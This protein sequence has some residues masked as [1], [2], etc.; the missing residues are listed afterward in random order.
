[1]PTLNQLSAQ[2]IDA[3]GRP[4]DSLLLER[5]KDILVQGRIQFLHRAFDKYGVD[6]EYVHP[7]IVPLEKVDRSL[8][9]IVPVGLT[10][11]KSVKRIPK[12]IRLSNETVPFNYVGSVDHSI[13]FQYANGYMMPFHKYL[14]L[15]G[16]GIKYDFVNEYLYI[17]N[18]TKLTECL[19]EALFE[20]F[21]IDLLDNTSNYERDTMEFP[22]YGDMLND[23]VNSTIQ[24]LTIGNDKAL[25]EKT[26]TRDV[27]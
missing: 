14:K 27:N 15:L 18:N 23:L 12:V 25:L 26:T 16:G 7:Y 4:F 13:T 3:L 5:V 1:M 17:L 21:D 9:S 6:R 8:D 2:V 11:L 10:W 22:L 20:I 24:S 19:I